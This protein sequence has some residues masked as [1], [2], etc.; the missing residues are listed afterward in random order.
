MPEL[1][2]DEKSKSSEQVIL[3][4]AEN[5]L[6]EKDYK[7]ARELLGKLSIKTKKYTD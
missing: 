3:D 2:T 6:N 5:A 4:D 1:V 7:T